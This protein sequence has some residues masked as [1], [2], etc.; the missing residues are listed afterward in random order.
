MSEH[1]ETGTAILAKKIK[2][3]TLKV[4]LGK[5]PRIIDGKCFYPFSVERGGIAEII[6]PLDDD[7]QPQKF[8]NERCIYFEKGDTLNAKKLWG[9]SDKLQRDRQIQK[10]VSDVRSGDHSRQNAEIRGKFCYVVIISSWNGENIK[11]LPL[12]YE[13]T[14][15]ALN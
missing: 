9:C 8:L 13:R 4:V 11:I 12:D 6:S 10:G 1:I 2:I 5:I 15:I 14:Q 7:E 3:N